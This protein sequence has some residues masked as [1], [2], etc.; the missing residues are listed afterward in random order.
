MLVDSRIR[1]N[2]VLTNLTL[3]V[4]DSKRVTGDVPNLGTFELTQC[5]KI[6][7]TGKDITD[8]LA[9][10]EVRQVHVKFTA[11]NN[12]AEGALKF[13]VLLDVVDAVE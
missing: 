11:A 8:D 9:P 4:G 10:A 5:T 12:V 1:F 6:T 2:N 13:D 3:K 7:C